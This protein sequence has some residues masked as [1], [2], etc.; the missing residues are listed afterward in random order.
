MKYLILITFVIGAEWFVHAASK[1]ATK[2]KA[3]IASPTPKPTAC[4]SGQVKWLKGKK[5]CP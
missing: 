5:V 1:V 3:P 4:V 2:P